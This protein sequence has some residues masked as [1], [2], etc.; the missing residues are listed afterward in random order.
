VS[1]DAELEEAF[2][3]GR[4]F[5]RR[6]RLLFEGVTRAA[7]W[8]HGVEFDS[9]GSW[10]ESCATYE[11]KLREERRRVEHGLWL[12]RR[13]G[14]KARPE[15]VQAL[16]E[17]DAVIASE[18]A[19]VVRAVDEVLDEGRGCAHAIAGMRADPQRPDG[20]VEFPDLDVF[21]EEDM[22]RA[23]FDWPSRRDAGGADFGHE[24]QLEDPFR[25]WE[26]T[27][28]RISWLCE[29]ASRLRDGEQPTQEVYALEIPAERSVRSGQRRGRVWLL[30]TLPDWKM[31]EQLL[32][33]LQ[34]HARRGRNSV[35]VAASAVQAAHRGEA[36][37]D[38][39]LRLALSV[40]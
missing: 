9:N 36:V 24:W 13:E 1:T 39:T 4:R 21:V 23:V 20:V 32:G 17:A 37:E 5:E 3:R 12:A 26:T 40:A 16:S 27:R 33:T 6:Q 18:L 22:R 8:A 28:W 31:A 14:E 34:P 35:V 7:P 30:G 19:K 10:F 11:R 29:S 25:R 15:E 38:L 2:E